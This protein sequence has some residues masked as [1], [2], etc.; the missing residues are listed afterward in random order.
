[1]DEGAQTVPNFLKNYRDDVVGGSVGNHSGEASRELFNYSVSL[2]V[3]HL[4]YLIR[5][6][7]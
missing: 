6:A 1:M 2:I 7:W 4:L 3:F 5:C